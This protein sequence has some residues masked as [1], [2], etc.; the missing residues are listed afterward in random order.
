MVLVHDEYHVEREGLGEMRRTCHRLLLSESSM[1]SLCN[2]T[3]AVSRHTN[4][5]GPATCSRSSHLSLN[6]VLGSTEP[7]QDM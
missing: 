2:P 6:A 7:C 5:L 4:D 3:I 1:V